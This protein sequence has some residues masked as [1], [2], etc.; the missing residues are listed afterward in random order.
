MTVDSFFID[1]EVGSAQANLT[2]KR[3]IDTQ[4]RMGALLDLMPN[5]IPMGL[6][7]HQEQ[8]ILFANNEACRLFDITK[9]E[10][11]GKHIFDFMT[12]SD[13]AAFLPKFMAAFNHE[14]TLVLDE[15]EFHFDGGRNIIANVIIA[16]LDWNGTKVVQVLIQDLTRL[17]MQERELKRLVMLDPLTGA[18]NRRFFIEHSENLLKSAHSEGRKLTML[19]MD[20]DFF[21]QVNDRYGHLG[22]DEALKTLVA[23]W[24]ANTRQQPREDGQVDGHLARMGGEEFAAIFADR[25]QEY[26]AAVAER[27][28]QVLEST[29][30][31]SEDGEFTITAS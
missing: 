8:G 11:L 16:R 1:D 12:T 2:K 21:K 13:V 25:E 30:I 19:L 14:H 15:I 27:F 24:Q 26:V 5:V 7:V 4:E 6:L 9:D 31:Q 10:I 28:R 29:I 17:K 3:L 23:L 18:Y 22:G 20:I